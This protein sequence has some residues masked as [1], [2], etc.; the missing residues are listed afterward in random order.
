MRG[1][2]K[3]CGNKTVSIKCVNI[4]VYDRNIVAFIRELLSSHIFKRSSFFK[5]FFEI[6]NVLILVSFRLLFRLCFFVTVNPS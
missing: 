3:T 1:T 5:N 4:L 2:I 6:S